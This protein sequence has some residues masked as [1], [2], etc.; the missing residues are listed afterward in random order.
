METRINRWQKH[1]WFAS[2]IGRPVFIC[3]GG[4][5]GYA[6]YA[7]AYPG[8]W[9][10]CA[11]LVVGWKKKSRSIVQNWLPNLKLSVPSTNFLQVATRTCCSV[12]QYYLVVGEKEGLIDSSK[13]VKLEALNS[14]CFWGLKQCVRPVW[15][16]SYVQLPLPIINRKPY[17]YC[18]TW[19]T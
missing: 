13:T 3:S 15:L 11:V 18:Y 2:H 16:I 9:S 19:C 1:R 17:E 6:G 12:S 4:P 14:A 8:A 10:F 5:T 7:A